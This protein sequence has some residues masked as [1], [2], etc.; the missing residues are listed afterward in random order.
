MSGPRILV[1]D[2]EPQ[3]RRLLEATLKARDYTVLLAADGKT[4]LDLAATERPE[5]I[6][7]DLGLPDLDG[8]EV[9]RR[10]RAW[11][12]V[13]IIILSVRD[14]EH[15]K[16]TAL[17]LG[18]DDYLTK[19]FG[20]HELLARLRVALRHANAGV[21]SDPVVHFGELEIDFN[22]RQVLR[23]GVPIHLTPT[24]YDLLRLLVT[25]VDRV[26]TQRYI[27]RAIWGLHS[28]DDARTLRVFIGQ[29]R[30]KIEPDPTQ[31]TYIH[32]EVGVGYRFQLLS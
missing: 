3:M 26:L 20:M 24:E 9:C 25:N 4:A 13:P 17:D 10:I 31:P 15:G 28:E 2:D 14:D 11:S 8:L 6:V 32:T 21:Q 23:A 19:P 7:L 27:L 16:V 22:R 18:A 1:V 12:Q 30:R 5:L 29:L